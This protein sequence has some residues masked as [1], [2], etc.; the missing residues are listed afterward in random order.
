MNLE[1]L[2]NPDVWLTLVTL[3]ALEIVLGIDN[4]VFIPTAVGGRPEERRPVARQCGIAVACITRICL[5]VSLALLARMHSDLFTVAGMGISMR[6][7]VLIVG[8]A[9]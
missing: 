1:F 5:L 9:F 7:L 3:S 8:G 6:D 2:A 4:L